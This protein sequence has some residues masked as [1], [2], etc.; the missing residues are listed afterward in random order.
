MR[1]QACTTLP[2]FQ[3]SGF[4]KILSLTRKLRSREF[5]KLFDQNWL[6]GG[7]S[8]RT[9]SCLIFPVCGQLG[10]FSSNRDKELQDFF[11]AQ[12]IYITFLLALGHFHFGSY[13]NL[14]R[15]EIWI[16]CQYKN[17]GVLVFASITFWL[18]LFPYFAFLNLHFALTKKDGALLSFFLIYRLRQILVA[19]FWL[20]YMV[21]LFCLL[22]VAVIYAA[23]WLITTFYLS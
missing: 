19:K 1:L 14:N 13:L 17:I 5:S 23:F 7:G 18:S 20:V 2:S 12:L 22:T 8:L 3:E 16:V 6:P 9:V 21:V 15:L 11:G 10:S 4:Y